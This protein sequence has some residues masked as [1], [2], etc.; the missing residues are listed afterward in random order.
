MKLYD[1]ARICGAGWVANAAGAIF[2]AASRDRDSS[3]WIAC[4]FVFITFI[5]LV[6]CK[7]NQFWP[8][9]N[10]EVVKFVLMH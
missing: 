10:R 8:S 6:I 9:V 3:D 7:S 1:L 4:V 2:L 5:C